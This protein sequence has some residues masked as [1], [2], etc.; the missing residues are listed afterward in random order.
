MAITVSSSLIITQVQC[1]TTLEMVNLG[2]A[3]SRTLLPKMMLSVG[4]NVPKD[5]GCARLEPFLS[6]LSSMK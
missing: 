4:L 2:Q 1:L 5:T 3:D 6:M